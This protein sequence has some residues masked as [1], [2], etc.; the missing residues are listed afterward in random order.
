MQYDA[1]GRTPSKPRCAGAPISFVA[2][3]SDDGIACIGANIA[4]KRP[5]GFSANHSSAIGTADKKQQQSPIVLP[6]FVCMA[7]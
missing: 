6:G 5:V 4:G 7:I 3:L 1:P 2:A